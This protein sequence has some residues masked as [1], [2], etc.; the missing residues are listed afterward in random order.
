MV[1]IGRATGCGCDQAVLPAQ[2]AV[3]SLGPPFACDA[4]LG[5]VAG[6][7]YKQTKVITVTTCICTCANG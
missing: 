7:V 2:D 6:N 5:A 4:M 1:F 3:G